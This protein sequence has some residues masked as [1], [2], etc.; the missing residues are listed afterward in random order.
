MPCRQLKAGAKYYTSVRQRPQAAGSG[1]SAPAAI[2][3]VLFPLLLPRAAF[4]HI[5]GLYY[6]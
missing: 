5:R 6:N 2:A 1:S 4:Y 3:A